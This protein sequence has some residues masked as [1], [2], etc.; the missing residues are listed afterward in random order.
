MP[1][2]RRMSYPIVP[3]NQPVHPSQIIYQH[4]IPQMATQGVTY[5]PY[6]SVPATQTIIYNYAQQLPQNF[7]GSGQ[8]YPYGQPLP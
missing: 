4:Q 3:N 1:S 6:G 2:A 8:Q 7:G 5:L